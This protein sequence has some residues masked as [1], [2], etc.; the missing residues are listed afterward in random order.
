MACT[1]WRSAATAQAT[2]TG[3]RPEHRGEERP[4]P[5]EG[6]VGVVEESADA[7]ADMLVDVTVDALHEE[8]FLAVDR[9]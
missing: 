2:L 4:E 6:I 7:A 1:Q 8:L 5:T 9:R 3:V